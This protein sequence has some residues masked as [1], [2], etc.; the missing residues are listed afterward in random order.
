M[1]EEG[2]PFC[3]H[4]GAPQIRV[5]MPETATPEQYQP[6][7]TPG[8]PAEMQPPAQ[9]VPLSTLPLPGSESDIQWRR[10][11]VPV[12][13]GALAMIVGA[14]VAPGGLLKLLAMAA[15]AAV[16]V[17]IYRRRPEVGTTLSGTAGAKLGAV[18]GL[19]SYGVLA[20]VIVIGCSVDS[21]DVRQ[22][23]HAQ[24]QQLQSQADPASRETMGQLIQKIDTPEGFAAFITA[25]L[26]IS[27]VMFLVCG[28]AGGA[29]SGAVAQRNQRR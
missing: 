10:A 11:F 17:A 8:T 5:A 22:Q 7:F 9:P 6:A 20:I 24:L 23:L 26:A 28:A 1:I 13:V 25:G 3:P 21:L 19:F 29:I 4:C 18:A 16:A 2:T 27:F 15:G 12:V 14:V